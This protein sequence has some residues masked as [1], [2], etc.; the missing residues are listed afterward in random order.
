MSENAARGHRPARHDRE[1]GRRRPRAMADAGINEPEDV[2]YVQTKT[3][4][5]TDRLR[6]ERTRAARVAS[7]SMNSMGVSNGLQRSASRL[8]WARSPCRCRTNLPGPRPLF[9]GRVLFV[10]R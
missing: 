5:L 4:L 7:R 3:P 6:S 9:L 8:R 2:H 10:G 1:G